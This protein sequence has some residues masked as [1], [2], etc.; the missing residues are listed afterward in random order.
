MPSRQ[1]PNLGLNGFWNL[2]E[3]WETGGDQNWL[4]LSVLSQCVVASATAAY[5][6]LP[7][8]GTVIIVP[9]SDPTNP[10]KLAAFDNG[11]WVY[12]TP[13]QGWRAWAVDTGNLLRYTGT[14][15]VTTQ[16][17]DSSAAVYHLAAVLSPS[18][19]AAN[20]TAEQ[21]F[22]VAGL[23]VGDAVFVNKPTAQTGLGVVGARVSAANTL[24]L[25]FSNNTASPI[26]PTANETYQ[27]GGVR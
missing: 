3:A 25:T 6:T 11:A 26:T 4:T 27:I 23:N 1:L 21:T 24:A 15:W 14:A 7:A 5:P 2:G 8:Q 13:K 16:A 10:G 9:A 20:T 22:A 17:G 12:F 19:V 18:A